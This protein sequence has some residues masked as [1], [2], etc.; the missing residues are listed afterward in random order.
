MKR[1]TVD[2]SALYHTDN[3]AVLCSSHLGAS[4]KTTGRDI[5]GQQIERVTDAD[6]SEWRR[7]VGSEIRC[8]TCPDSDV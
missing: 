5:S 2:T 3:G 8:E 1:F 6:R 4:A 7:L